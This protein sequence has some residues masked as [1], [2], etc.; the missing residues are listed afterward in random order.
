MGTE[1]FV[2]RLESSDANGHGDCLVF[3]PWVKIRQV[4][5]EA[6][7]EKK[8]EFER[9]PF[10]VDA[11]VDGSLITAHAGVPLVVELF[12]A[13]GAAGSLPSGKFGANAGWFR[14]NALTYN[15]LSLL[16]RV[17]LPG[18][19]WTARPKRLRFLLFNTVEKVVHHA[20]RMFL[21]LGPE[22]HRGLFELA[23][24]KILAL[25]YA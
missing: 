11:E 2:T 4:E 19:F 10:E 17:A 12:R 13:S 1:V 21:R 23:R 16:Q 8:L 3:T 20:R 15:L 18:E 7:P 22:V 9:L 14:L 25:G 24:G 6:M 5:E